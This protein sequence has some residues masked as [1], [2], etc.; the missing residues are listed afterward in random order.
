[1]KM[2][3][4]KFKIML[5]GLV[6]AFSSMN[7][8]AGSGHDHGHGHS[9]APVSAET[10]KA[11]AVQILNQMV[12]EKVLDMSWRSVP[13]ASVQKKAVNG[14]EEWVVTF[15]NEKVSDASKKTL[16]IFLSLS[17]EYEA[18]NFTGK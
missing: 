18:A 1:M 6:L 10:A 2:K 8:F 9:Q 14:Q 7:A 11:N 13:V 4:M 17:G 16:Y 15:V 12:E 5:L 3:I